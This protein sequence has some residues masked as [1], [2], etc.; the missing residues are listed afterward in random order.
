MCRSSVEE[1]KEDRTRKHRVQVEQTE[2]EEEGGEVAS[3]SEEEETG[4]EKEE[5]IAGEQ[6]QAKDDSG[7]GSGK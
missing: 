1:A 2:E 5:L 6:H 3:D 4:V 7:T